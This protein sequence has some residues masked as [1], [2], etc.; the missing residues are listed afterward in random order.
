MVDWPNKAVP[1]ELVFAATTSSDR[2]SWMEAMSDAIERA[3]SGAPTCGWLWKEGGRKSGLS[4]GGWKRRWFTLPRGRVGQDSEL[5]YFD[6]PQAASV[7]GSIR[8][9]RSD[10]FI[11][12]QVRGI[13]AEYRHNF[14]VTSQ[15]VEKGKPITICTLLAAM[16]ERDRD[17]WVLSLSNAIKGKQSG[18]RKPASAGGAA[19]AGGST[20]R[21]VA[22]TDVAA[23]SL[24]AGAQVNL[25]QMMKLEPDVLVELRS[26]P[27]VTVPMPMPSRAAPS[28]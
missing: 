5:R 28:C 16:T 15:G 8:L 10:V 19:A 24:Q 7:K 14:C 2:A 6:S 1:H 27:F 17:M 9:Q 3:L 22:G 26:E 18:G 12:R 21:P 20:A 13:R 11:P 25:E 23:A 4:L